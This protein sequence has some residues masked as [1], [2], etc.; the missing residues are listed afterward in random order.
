VAAFR[1]TLEE[2][3]EADLVI[4][5][6]DISDPD[7]AAQAEDVERILSDLGVDASDAE[8]VVEVWNKVDLIDEASREQLLVGG[9]RPPVAI[10]AVT[11]EG[12][13]NLAALI[14]Q[15]IAGRLQVME[16]TLSSG[17]LGL[18]DWVYRGGDVLERED[19]ED[20]SVALTLRATQMRRDEII[21]RLHGR[22]E[23]EG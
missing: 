14:E 13:D 3:I 11:G 18:L 19:R 15:R 17:Q 12:V 6:R 7:M 16:I 22:P 4:H 23:D 2:V 9:E 8:H 10:S 21:S 20:G 5:L 1:A